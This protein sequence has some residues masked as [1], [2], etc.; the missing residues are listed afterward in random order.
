MGKVCLADE[1]ALVGAAAMGKTRLVHELIQQLPV[2]RQ[3]EMPVASIILAGSPP[4]PDLAVEPRRCGSWARQIPGWTEWWD[5]PGQSL[6][7]WPWGWRRCAPTPRRP[8][9]GRYTQRS[10]FVAFG[11][12]GEEHF[13]TLQHPGAGSPDRPRAGSRSCPVCAAAEA[14]PGRAWRRAVS[15]TK[16]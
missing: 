2:P 9:L 8:G 16:R 11:D 12:E 14:K 5:P 1:F 4:A 15:C 3:L 13:G 6:R 10:P 7:R